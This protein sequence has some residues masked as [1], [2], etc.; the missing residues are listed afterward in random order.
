MPDTALADSMY[1]RWPSASREA[2]SRMR[3]ATAS[4]TAKQLA[5]SLSTTVMPGCSP[6]WQSLTHWPKPARAVV[7][8]GTLNARLSSGV[9]PQGSQ[10]DGNTVRSR[11]MSRSQYDLSNTPSLPLRYDGMKWTFTRSSAALRRPSSAKRLVMVSHSGLERL[12][13]VWVMQPAQPSPAILRSRL[14]SGPLWPDGIITNACTSRPS[15]PPLRRLAR[16]SMNT[17]SPLL[18]YSY[19]PPIPTST[20]SSATGAPLMAAA[21]LVSA[22][23]AA[24]RLASYSSRV[25]GVKLGSKPLGV[26]MSTFLPQNCAHSRAVM[27]LTVVRTSALRAE[28]FSSE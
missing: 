27:S 21:T 8:V 17:S 5:S 28:F 20:A 26:T 24:V 14:R 22:S 1:A 18:R 19:L 6:S 23:R 2:I 4:T 9:Q 13:E 25:D 16:A 12:C 15:Q 11:P 7:S 3:A 10:Q